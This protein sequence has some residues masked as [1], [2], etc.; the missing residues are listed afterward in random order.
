MDSRRV[1]NGGHAVC[2]KF[3]NEVEL[4]VEAKEKRNYDRRT[5]AMNTGTRDRKVQLQI[6]VL[7]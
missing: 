3:C 4:K 1:R 2:A 6:V 7:L 5:A